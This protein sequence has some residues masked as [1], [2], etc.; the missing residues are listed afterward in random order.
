MRRGL[1]A[2]MAAHVVRNLEQ[3]SEQFPDDAETRFQLANACFRLGDVAEP[4]HERQP[5]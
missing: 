5:R 2:D 1:T 4:G 3:L